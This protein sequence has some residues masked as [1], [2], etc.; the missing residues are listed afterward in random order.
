M[1]RKTLARTTWVLLF[2]SGS[3]FYA[4]HERHTSPVA[5]P[6]N[7]I[8]VY[9]DDMGFGDLGRTGAVGYQTPNLDQMAKDGMFLSQFL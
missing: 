2:V 5:D 1:N 8:L 7:I 3:L 4:F 6:P 9:F